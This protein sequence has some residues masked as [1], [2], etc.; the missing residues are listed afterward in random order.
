MALDINRIQALCF[1]IDGTLSDTDD[2]YVEKFEKFF[3]PFSFLFKDRDSHRAARRF[4]MWSTAPANFI[5]GL[6]DV[7][8]LDDELAAMTDWLTR[9]RPRSLKHFI[10][11]DG[12]KEMLKTLQEHYPMAVVT[13]RNEKGTMQFLE[14]YNLLPFFDIVVSA[15]TAEHSKPYPDPVIYAA[16]AM[17]IPVENC[18]MIGD[19]TVDIRAGKSAAAQ[20]AGV[21]CG[22]GE[23]NALMQHGADI[24]LETTS[25]LTPILLKKQPLEV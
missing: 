17:N 11:I 2:Q 3:R 8:G 21:L 18:L 14:Q 7:Y 22:F 4:V 9:K 20:T 5:Y 1:D 24:I 12:I 6:P 15:L 16:K 13:A 25:D 23:R 10:L 19:T